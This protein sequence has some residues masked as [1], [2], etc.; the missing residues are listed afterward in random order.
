[1]KGVKNAQKFKMVERLTECK[2]QKMGIVAEVKAPFSIIVEA[3]SRKRA[4]YEKITEIAEAVQG[5]QDTIHSVKHDKLNLLNKRD[6]REERMHGL[7]QDKIEIEMENTLIDSYSKVQSCIIQAENHY[8]ESPFQTEFRLDI[9]KLV[10]LKGKIA[11]RLFGE[12]GE[13]TC[14]ATATAAIGV[15][16][17][18]TI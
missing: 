12:E 5:H 6:A 16:P 11:K 9:R 1:M 8:K 14:T 13:H 15:S 10:E 7:E 17:L 4:R 18:A 3:E 2:H